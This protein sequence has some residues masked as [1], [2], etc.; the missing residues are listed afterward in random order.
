MLII[1]TLVVPRL[2]ISIT[3]WTF[4]LIKIRGQIL[5]RYKSFVLI[6]LR[7]LLALVMEG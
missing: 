5:L 6:V 3:T 4:K 2:G 1:V 7:V